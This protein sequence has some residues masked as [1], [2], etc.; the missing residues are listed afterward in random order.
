M[1]TLVNGKKVENLEFRTGLNGWEISQYYYYNNELVQ[2]QY[3]TETKE[4]KIVN[5]K[6]EI[7]YNL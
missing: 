6:G 1:H 5:A 4:L 2:Q 3:N 7:L